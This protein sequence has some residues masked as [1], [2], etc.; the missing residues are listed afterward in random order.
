MTSFRWA[1]D[2]C[3][4]NRRQ[5][6]SE[7]AALPSL[8][9][10]GGRTSIGIRG[11]QFLINGEPTYKGRTWNGDRIEGL[12]MNSRMVQGIFDDANPATVQRWAYP[13]TGRWDPLWN[14]REFIAAMP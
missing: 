11:D 3:E 4:M 8:A 13:D 14:T 1:Y 6:L 5:F 7:V 12:L 9:S 10:T 2:R